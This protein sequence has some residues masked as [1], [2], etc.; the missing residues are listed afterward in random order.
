MLEPH[1]PRLLTGLVRI[2]TRIDLY[3]FGRWLVLALMIGV[4]AGLG[5]AL[6][7]WGV[8]GVASVLHH[9][10]VGF[11]APGHGA[12]G[13][14]TWHPPS[15]PW[16][17]LLV[18]PGAGLLVGWIVTTFAPEA[19]GHGTDAVINAYHRNGALLRRR[20]IPIKL[21]ASA[22]TI[23]SGGSAGREGPVAHIS[24]GFASYLSQLLRLPTLDRRILVIC[25]MA[26]GIGG[27][28]RAPLG[29][30]LFAIEVLY[31]ENDY[32]SEALIP[33]IMSS[34]VAY[35]V[36][37]SLT[38]WHPIFST[39]V[40]Q[41]TTPRELGAYLLLGI[42]LAVVGVVYVKVFYGMRD[43]VFARIPV[44]AMVKPAIGGLL[45][46]LLALVVPQVMSGGYG[47]LQLTLDGG[48]PFKVLVLLLPAKILAT[49]FTISSGGS[50]GVFAPSLVIGG[51]TGAVF[52]AAAERLTPGFA[53]AT[54]ACVL[55]GMGG[56]FAGV[57]K[58]PIASLIMVA[59]MSGSYHL[60]VP[61]M[62]VCSVTFLLMRGVSIYEAQVATRIDSPAH[63]GE[64]QMDVL[65]RLAVRQVMDSD[66][67]LI[68]VTPGTPFNR[69]IEIVAETEQHAFPVVDTENL[70]VGLFSMTDVR[71]M[72]ASPEVWSLLVASDLAVAASSMAYLEPDDDLHTAVRRFTAFR[73]ETL[74]VLSA[75]PP[76]AAVGML[77]YRRV[78][79]AYDEE[80][81]RLQ[82]EHDEVGS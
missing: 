76:S 45:V 28:F 68:T 58:V 15:R 55:V 71:R 82:S 24:A 7:T 56:F 16:L 79:E 50:G 53:P 8:D 38:G 81:Q 4:V 43:V 3:N 62:L 21:V 48:L 25:G 37:A 41:F 75:P 27:M 18:L 73:H 1:V 59:E 20:I 51:V 31:S 46:G 80:I 77:S 12:T 10:V 52:A 57:A 9:R 74:P 47:W 54:A 49:S 78:L 14:T 34:I 2:A 61:L 67:E 5:A 22:L 33:A 23:G 35:V 40:E 29:A 26:A 65:E 39:N 17:L 60:L 64:L 32:E 36:N 13:S 6:L 11:E 72:M 30:A 70:V 63:I 66:Q 42:V 44:P 69:I 19:E